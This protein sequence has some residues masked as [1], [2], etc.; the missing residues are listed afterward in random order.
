MATLFLGELW[1]FK[2]ILLKA[3]ELSYLLPS[4]VCIQRIDRGKA[5]I[6]SLK[7][8]WNLHVKLI[9]EK[10]NSILRS[11]K[12]VIKNLNINMFFNSS[13]PT[14]QVGTSHSWSGQIAEN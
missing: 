14:I 11:K 7:P 13:L 9:L 8:S 3:F 5:Q 10:E 12:N 6:Y 4:K 1:P 2:F